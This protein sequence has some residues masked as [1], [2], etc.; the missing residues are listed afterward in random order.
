MKVQQKHF[1]EI[2]PNLGLGNGPRQARMDMQNFPSPTLEALQTE[3]E[4]K[5]KQ[6]K[7]KEK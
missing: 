1:E 5:R 3:L 2:L 4:E 6:A 7:Q